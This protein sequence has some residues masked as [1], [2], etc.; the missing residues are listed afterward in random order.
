MGCGCG[1][2]AQGELWEVVF[3]DGTVSTGTSKA[4]ATATSQQTSGSWIRK[5]ERVLTN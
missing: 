1:E 2:A 3:A 5:I 4:E